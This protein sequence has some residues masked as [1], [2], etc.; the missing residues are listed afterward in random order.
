MIN[1]PTLNLKS[2]T[3]HL[4]LQI[5]VLFTT[6]KIHK[7]ISK[8]YCSVFIMRHILFGKAEFLSCIMKPQKKIGNANA[9]QKMK[10]IMRTIIK[11]IFL[12]KSLHSQKVANW[13]WA[14]LDSW[15]VENCQQEIKTRFL[16]DRKI[17]KRFQTFFVP[18]G[19]FR[20]W[21]AYLDIEI[22]SFIGGVPWGSSY[23]S[24]PIQKTKP[25]RPK[26]R[27]S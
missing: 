7:S 16:G 25:C 22:F 9:L 13:I 3:W 12:V 20:H 19:L 23:S 4:D 26:L 27:M 21:K 10:S 15:Y 2:H 11:L 24:S 18:K 14:Y 8:T 5:R 1:Q 17:Y 6:T